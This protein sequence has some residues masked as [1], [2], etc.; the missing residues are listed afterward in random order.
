MQILQKKDLRG[1]CSTISH[2]D[3]SAITFFEEHHLADE[4]ELVRSMLTA[5]TIGRFLRCS[6]FHCPEDFYFHSHRDN[7]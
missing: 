4:E 3:I 5:L 7:N 1:W 6:S 2:L